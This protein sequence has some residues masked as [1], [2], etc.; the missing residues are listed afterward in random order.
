MNNLKECGN[1]AIIKVEELGIKFD[2]YVQDKI[3]EIQG[4]TVKH[5]LA[6]AL[7]VTYL[8]TP[9]INYHKK[10]HLEIGKRDTKK[11]GLEA[12]HG[13]TFLDA[14]GIARN[15]DFPIPVVASSR[16]ME[17]GDSVRVSRKRRRNNY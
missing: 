9:P 6:T 17:K 1:E 4:S 2:E 3:A 7:E 16:K 15:T 8:I 13:V 12:L 14:D 5:C 11:T 10:Y